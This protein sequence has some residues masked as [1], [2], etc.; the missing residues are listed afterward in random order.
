MISFIRSLR[1]QVRGTIVSRI[2]SGVLALFCLIS[3]PLLIRQISY[4]HLLVDVGY[5]DSYVLYDVLRFQKTGLI[6]HDLSQEPYLPTQYSPMMYMLFSLPGRIMALENPFLGPRL[7]VI[8]S[9]L[10]CIAIVT[11]IVRTL[12]PARFTWIWGVLLACTISSMWPWVLQIRADFSGICFSLLAIR[13]LLSRSRWAV[14]LAGG[15]AGLAMQF[16]ITFVAALATGALWLLL[17]RASHSLT[18][19]LH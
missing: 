1:A 10:L 6:Y 11:S 3:I 2:V 5:G 8:A 17:F 18:R 15:S 16:K 4:L 7:V 13:L 12:I 9:F 14:F 19:D